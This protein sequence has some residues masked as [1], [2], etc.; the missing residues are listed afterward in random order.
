MDRVPE[1]RNARV[2]RDEGRPELAIQV[3]RPKAALLGLSVTGVANSIRTNVGGTQAAFFRESGNEYPIIVRLREEDRERVED[4]NDDPRQQRRQGQVLQAKSLLTLR[5]Q[6][7]PTEIQRK[8]QERIIRV[9]AEPEA[10]LS[11][12]VAAVNSR[13]PEVHVPQDFSVGFGSEVEEQAPRV[14]PAAVDADPRRAC[15]STP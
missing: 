11:D 13:L 14:Q 9:T 2:G 5:N 6:S 12:A 8:N 10:A 3:D 1:V 4:I 15:W 7:G